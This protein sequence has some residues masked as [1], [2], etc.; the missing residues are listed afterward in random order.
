MPASS[1]SSDSASTDIPADA[2]IS[3]FVKKSVSS[4]PK[5]GCKFADI[6]IE[7]L[8]GGGKVSV[9]KELKAFSKAKIALVDLADMEKEG[10]APAVPLKEPESEAM[11]PAQPAVL[12]TS[13]AGTFTPLKKIM[14]P[15]ST[16]TQHDHIAE[17]GR[18]I[19]IG[20]YLDIPKLCSSRLSSL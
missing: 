19:Y 9:D 7:Y 3:A 6:P 11:L 18:S 2:I 10:A 1:G 15:I 5:T 14:K 13:S 16:V 20:S 8:R 12:P 17:Y 4:G